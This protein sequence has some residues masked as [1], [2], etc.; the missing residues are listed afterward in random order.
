MKSPGLIRRG[1][2]FLTTKNEDSVGQMKFSEICCRP[3]LLWIMPQDL[4][5]M[6]S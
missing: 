4:K 5:D 6:I 3:R 1:F 2:S